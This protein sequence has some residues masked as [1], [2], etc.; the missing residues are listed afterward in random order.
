MIFEPPYKLA[1]EI[2]PTLQACSA[3]AVQARTS[4]SDPLRRIEL[5]KPAKDPSV[6][7]RTGRWSTTSTCRSSK[8]TQRSSRYDAPRAAEQHQLPSVGRH[9]SPCWTQSSSSRSSLSSRLPSTSSNIL[10]NQEIREGKKSAKFERKT[11]KKVSLKS[12]GS[13]NRVV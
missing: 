4:T 12:V 11:A 6:R 1:P 7:W 8:Q 13:Q 2:K 10:E 9:T 3:C 5:C